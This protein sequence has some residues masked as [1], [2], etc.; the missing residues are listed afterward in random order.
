M[1]RW[2]D[3]FKNHP[4]QAVWESIKK[5]IEN[6]TVDDVTVITSVN[7]LARLKK[8]ISY[9]D[10]A[11][12]TLDPELVPQSTWDNFHSQSNACL[13]QITNYRSNRNIQH[14]VNANGH[15]DNLLTYIRPYMIAPKSVGTVLSKALKNYANNMDQYLEQF[16][17]KSNDLLLEIGGYRDECS[18][19]NKEIIDINSKV[20]EFGNELFGND[21]KVEGVK[22]KITDLT[23]QIESMHSQISDVYDEI[24]VGDE[25]NIS[26]SKAVTKAKEAVL[27]KQTEV[28]ELLESVTVEVNDL[29]NFYIKIFGVKSNDDDEVTEGGLENE[30]NVRL[31]ALSDFESKQSIKYKA[32]I[33]KIEELLPGATTAGLASAYLEMKNSFNNPIRNS[34]IVFYIAIAVLVLAAGFLAIDTAGINDKGESYIKFVEFNQWDMVLKGLIYKIPF[35][36]PI[37][38]LAYYASKRRSEY[39]RLQQEYAHKEAL[40]KSYD[41]YKKQLLEIDD[42]DQTM[43]QAFLTKAID[44][45]AFNAS[46]TLDGKHGDKMPSHDA[47]EKSL[48]YFSKLKEIATLKN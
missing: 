19:L 3:L 5:N 2:T 45:I 47:I 48:D 41:S 30:L 20:Q 6:E 13:Q 28:E 23:A 11:L 38:W 18:E 1:S 42:K 37:I 34:S 12:S 8:V 46:A 44:A 26:T 40:A 10:G 25:K 31:K 9:L 39:Q 22:D 15:A 16:Q 29:N 35:Y 14:I 21:E 27:A 36:G 43:L 24:L 4:F 33:E 17:K 32:L 7:E